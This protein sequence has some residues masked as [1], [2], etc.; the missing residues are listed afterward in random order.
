M[1]RNTVLSTL[2]VKLWPEFGFNNK[3]YRRLIMAK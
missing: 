2:K 1:D 3:Y